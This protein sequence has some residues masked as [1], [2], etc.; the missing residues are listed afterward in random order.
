MVEEGEGC[1][2]GVKSFGITWV[3]NPCVCYSSLD[4]DLDAALCG[5][6]SL[7][8][9]DLGGSSSFGMDTFGARSFCV[10]VRVIAHWKGGWVYKGNGVVVDVPVHV[11]NESPEVVDA[12]DMVV[13]GFE[14]D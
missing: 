13:G 8:V 6:I 12:V 7:I 3:T 10:D 1:N 5:L 11:G 9:L 14:K 2:V 4:E